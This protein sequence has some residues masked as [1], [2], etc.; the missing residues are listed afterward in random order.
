LAI[1]NFHEMKDHIANPIF[2]EKRKIEMALE[3]EFPETYHSK[4]SLV[5]FKETIGY[6]EAMTVGRAQDKAILSLLA[7]QKIDPKDSL[8]DQLKKVQEETNSILSEDTIAK[9]LKH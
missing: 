5:T 3:A 6:N 1:D 4:Y 8:T 7:H 9:T 2:Q